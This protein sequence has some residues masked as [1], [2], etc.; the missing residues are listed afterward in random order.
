MLY[1]LTKGYPLAG[2]TKKQDSN[3][4][5]WVHNVCIVQSFSQKK[6]VTLFFLSCLQK[7]YFPNMYSSIE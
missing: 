4:D 5:G 7:S 1:D 3:T 2:K 6:K